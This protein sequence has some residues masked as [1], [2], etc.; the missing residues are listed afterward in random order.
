M[1]SGEGSAEEAA[2]GGGAGAELAVDAEEGLVGA[3]EA[4]RRAAAH[5]LSV[6]DRRRRADA[7]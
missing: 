3:G 5:F 7:G 2:E 6:W 1:V 4:W